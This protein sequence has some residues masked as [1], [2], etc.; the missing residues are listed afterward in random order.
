MGKISYTDEQKQAIDTLDRSILVA[1]AA[2]SGKTAVLIQR[3]VNIILQGKADVDEMLIVTFTNAA[4]AEMRTKLSREIRKRMKED[5]DSRA[6]LNEQLDKLFKAYISTF[7]SFA[8]RIIKEFFY[9]IDMEPNFRI[10][11]ETEAIMMKNEAID[12]LFEEAF[13]NDNLIEGGSF[14]DFLRLYSGDR[15]EDTIKGEII[16]AYDK[17]RTMPDY[18]EWARNSL[19]ALDMDKETFL[20]SETGQY[21][22]AECKAAVDKAIVGMEYI[23]C[24]FSDEGVEKLY[25][26][27]FQSEY[28]SMIAVRDSLTRDC[29]DPDILNTVEFVRAPSSVKAAYKDGYAMIKDEVKEVRDAYKKSFLS[30]RDEFFYPDLETRLEEMR[31]SGKYTAYY[32]NLLEAFECRYQAIKKDGGLIDFGDAEH[33]AARILKDDDVA[34]TLR[35]RFK[36]IFIDEYQDTNNIQE[37]LIGR[38]ARAD[39][40]FKVGDVKQSI[41]RFRLAEPAIFQETYREYS[42]EANAD[43][44]A[45]DL[46]KNFRCNPRSVDYINAVFEEIMP[47]YDDAARLYA[48]VDSCPAEFDF[49]PEVHVLLN[50][51]Q[52]EYASEEEDEDNLE[53]MDG[54]FIEEEADEEIRQLSVVEAEAEYVAAEVGKLLGTEF[55][56]T[57]TGERR[58]VQARDIVILLR[59]MKN[60][61][62]RYAAALRAL[63]VQTYVE[64]D[65]NYY[66]T[67]EIRQAQSLLMTID[68]FKRD[69]PLIAT[70]HSQIFKFGAD[71]LATI[72]AEHKA[73]LRESKQSTR[74]I[75]YWRAVKWYASYGK[76]A[77]IQEKL[78]SA[79]QTLEYWKELSAMM[80]LSDFIWKVITESDFYLYVGAMSDGSRRQANLRALA[81]RAAAFAKD[82][83]VSLS[84]FIRYLEI[85]KGRK[86][87]SGQAGMVGKDDDVVRIQTIHKSKG[88]EYPFVIIAGLGTK[89]RTDN[90]SKGFMLDTK[91]G[92]GLSYVSPDKKFWRATIRQRMMFE[93]GI[94]ESMEEELRV[95]YVAMTRAR[96]KL[97]LVGTIKGELQTLLADETGCKCFYELMGSRLSTK[98]NHLEIA[99][100]NREGA[101]RS[102]SKASNVIENCMP[103]ESVLADETVAAEVARRLDYSYPTAKLELKAKYS[104]SELRRE[105]LFAEAEASSSDDEV[106]SILRN[107]NHQKTRAKSTDIGIAYHRIMEFVDFERAVSESGTVNTEYIRASVSHLLDCGAIDADAYEMLELGHIDA[108]FESPLGLRA[109]AAAR[110]GSLRKEKPFTLVREKDGQSVLVQGVIDCCFEEDGEMVVIDY[111]SSFVRKGIAHELELKRIRKEY[112]VQLELYSEAIEQGT[113]LSVKEAYLYLFLSDEA[114]RIEADATASACARLGRF[115]RLV[116]MGELEG[117]D[118]SGVDS[119]SR[120]LIEGLN[121]ALASEFGVSADTSLGPAPDDDVWRTI[122]DLVVQAFPYG[123]YRTKAKDLARQIHQLRYVISAQQA[124]YV[125]AMYPADCDEDSL[126]MYF[127]GLGDEWSSEESD[128]LHN[129]R[130]GASSRNLL[131]HEPNIKLVC[132]NFHSEFI[133]DNDGNFLYILNPLGSENDII[134]GSS[135]NY[136]RG[137]DLWLD[138]AENPLS[139]HGLLDVHISKLDPAFRRKALKGWFSPSLM[140]YKI[141][142]LWLASVARKKRFKTKVERYKG[143]C[144]K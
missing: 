63:D 21:L 108:F 25:E 88:L 143:D 15:N 54:E 103:S 100:L 89:F 86:V 77:S 129:K 127:A 80:P 42:D 29:F 53:A 20:K 36:Y 67:I 31:C 98:F 28:D 68:N 106:V 112:A 124:E 38:I 123:L 113:D 133:L 110:R 70:L 131:R 125:R 3:I 30:I 66:D 139:I 116:G 8:N 9:L 81:D 45:I 120:R 140:E 56:D 34:A 64:D 17:L 99:D 132:E 137:N 46:N 84:D 32:L 22:E 104:V 142:G 136:A 14:R 18:F 10:C 107:T 33:T 52:T 111:K 119:E 58:K 75:P 7:N 1:A 71:E 138:G 26:E 87:D 85:L 61:G 78:I 5:P 82:S 73:M 96:N 47:G 51:D 11:D 144:V 91:L 57:A 55:F 76:D 118:V 60:K 126:A 59:K 94:R 69:V 37:A 95:L 44:I 115:C 27:K 141:G 121:S 122:S 109:V 93:K 105:V 79:I 128:R 43:A 50:G 39:N 16:A 65:E 23:Q 135:F 134:N 13:E 24:L 117:G 41:Y 114:V 101:Y 48:G 130:T 62:D 97:I 40:V 74:N 2:G 12:Q 49:V 72:R 4:A 19:S 35:N 6:M 90:I 102:R 83:I 92:V